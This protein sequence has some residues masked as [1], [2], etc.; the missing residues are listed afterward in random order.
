MNPEDQY[1]RKPPLVLDCNLDDTGTTVGDSHQH[2][3]RVSVGGGS[4]ELAPF[5]ALTALTSDSGGSTNSRDIIGYIG[6]EVSNCK[7][8]KVNGTC[9][10]TIDALEMVK[11]DVPGIFTD[12]DGAQFSYV[13]SGLDLHLTQAVHGIFY[14]TRGTIVFPEDAFVG[15]ISIDQRVAGGISLG[16][17]QS[18]QEFGQAVGTL[19]K[20]GKLQLSLTLTAPG[21]VLSTTLETM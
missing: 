8:K 16:P 9:D 12:S 11:R 18:V 1:G 10:V 19:T 3:S 5:R 7:E 13:V 6:Y 21:G 20:E 4:S 15:T 17:W 14:P 2:A